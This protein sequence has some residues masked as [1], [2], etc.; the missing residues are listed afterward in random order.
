MLNRW[1][2]VVLTT[3]IVFSLPSAAADKPAE[4]GRYEKN[5]AEFEARDREQPPPEDGILFV[6]SSTIRLWDLA[7]CFPGM[8]AYNR[9]FGGSMVSEVNDV[10]ERIVFPYAP[11][12]IVFYSGDNDIAHGKTPEQTAADFQ[13]FRDRVKENLPQAH[14]FLLSIKPSN[15]RWELWPKMQEANRLLK[16]LCED[17]EHFHFLDTSACMLDAEGK[18][19]KDLLQQDGLHLN[20]KG[21]ELWTELVMPHLKTVLDNAK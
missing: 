21:Y 1:E 19:R 9:G 4:A 5:M 8:P 12:A 18:P 14:V 3:T 2:V 16:G 17:E 13:T 10:A 11:K 6:G 15:A 20:E 7:K